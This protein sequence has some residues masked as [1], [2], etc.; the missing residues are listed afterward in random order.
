VRSRHGG[1]ATQ[2]GD[3]GSNG[4]VAAVQHLPYLH[5]AEHHRRRTDVPVS[6]AEGRSS[7]GTVSLTVTLCPPPG[8]LCTNPIP[9]ILGDNPF[10]TTGLGSNATL[11]C[12]GSGEDIFFSFTPANSQDYF[13]G[14]CGA[15]FDTVI[16]VRSDCATQIVCDD[17]GCGDG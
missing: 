5:R 7:N 1:S 10:T 2:A 4:D 13:I 17:D 16:G 9:A 15:T 12:G 11:T 14:V 8:D 3:D 6:D